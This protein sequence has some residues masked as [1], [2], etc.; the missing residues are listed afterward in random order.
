MKKTNLL[1]AV[2]INFAVFSVAATPVNADTYGQA[3][4]TTTYGQAGCLGTSTEASKSAV[5]LADTAIDTPT[6]AFAS[7]VMLSGAGAFFLK[8]KVA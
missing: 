4:C 6:L 8:R 3:N 5:Y 7:V 1:L 2:L